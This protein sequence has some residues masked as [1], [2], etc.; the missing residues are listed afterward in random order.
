MI[1]RDTRPTGTDDSKG[2]TLIIAVTVL[3]VLLA[4]TVLAA[5]L[6][7]LGWGII[8]STNDQPEPRS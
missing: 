3:N 2:L 5:L 8:T 7:L 1:V 6:S 4:L